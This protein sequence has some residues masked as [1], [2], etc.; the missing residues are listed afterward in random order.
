[1]VLRPRPPVRLVACLA[2]R[3]AGWEKVGKPL[4]RTMKLRSALPL[5][6]T[7]PLSLQNLV[8]VVGEPWGKCPAGE[9]TLRGKESA[10]EMKVSRQTPQ[11]PYG[12]EL[13]SPK[14]LVE[15]PPSRQRIHA[16]NLVMSLAA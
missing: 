3:K 13:C 11:D 12:R 16:Q 4:H 6:P 14:W 7:P 5:P 1:M 2:K 15:K 10:S 9:L 8:R